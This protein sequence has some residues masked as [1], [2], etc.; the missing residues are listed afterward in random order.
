[1]N[2]VKLKNKASECNIN[3]FMSCA[4]DDDRSVL[5]V[6]GKP[7]PKQLHEAWNNI[8]TEFNDIS[9]QS[10]PMEELVLMRQIL[11]LT[12]RI[13]AMSMFIYAHEQAATLQG[14]DV[15][16]DFSLFT[17]YGYTIS[18]NGN[19]KH[20]LSQLQQIKQSELAFEFDLIDLEKELKELQKK[21][22]TLNSSSSRYNFL[23]QIKNIELFYKMQLNFDSY[24]I[25]RLAV[26]INGFRK[27]VE[28][29]NSNN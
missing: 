24:S 7:T 23:D 8:L 4:F 22:A 5:I 28:R 11:I 20:F 12:A 14:I 2:V 3:E 10:A 1:M 6:S 17:E 27:M 21:D 9:G 15:I 25:E 26:L 18:Y 13:K 16:E 29:Q 19:K